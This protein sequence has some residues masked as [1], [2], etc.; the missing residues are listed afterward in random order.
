MASAAPVLD[1]LSLWNLPTFFSNDIALSQM[2]FQA[3]KRIK[4]DFLQGVA[5][6]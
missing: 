1:S 6:H 4:D 5:T 3:G 2:K